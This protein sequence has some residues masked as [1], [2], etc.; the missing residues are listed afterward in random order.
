MKKKRKNRDSL[1]S[2]RDWL[3]GFA[4]PEG[5]GEHASPSSFEKAGWRAPSRVRAR[6]LSLT[7]S[8][9][10]EVPP[11]W[12]Q[13]DEETWEFLDIMSLL[14]SGPDD[15]TPLL[16]ETID[17]PE[18]GETGSRSDVLRGA[19]W[20]ITSRTAFSHLVFQL[21]CDLEDHPGRWPN[22]SLVSF[23]DALAMFVANG[24]DDRCRLSERTDWHTFAEILLA[25]KSYGS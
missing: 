23:L 16:P 10:A 11:L 22:K 17:E 13:L 3:P 21:R 1:S 6:P 24:G 14:P 20:A 15:G 25:A 12:E 5:N 19:R 9:P 7:P 4:A 18:D 8:V 2:S